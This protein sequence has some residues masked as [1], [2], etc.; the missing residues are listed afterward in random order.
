MKFFNFVLVLAVVKSFIL[1]S[2]ISE[3]QNIKELK[4]LYLLSFFGNQKEMDALFKTKI[5][6]PKTI[7]EVGSYLGAST[8]YLANQLAD[9]GALY[10]VDWWRGLNYAQEK[11]VPGDHL[12]GWGHKL[13]KETNMYEQFL[14]NMVHLGVDSK[15]FP[16]RSKTLDAVA[17]LHE[18]GVHQ[19]DL[20]YIDADHSYSVVLEELKA[21]FH[22][23]EGKKGIIC[24]DDWLWSAP[25]LGADYILGVQKA[26]KKFCLDRGLKYFSVNNFWW[27]EE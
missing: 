7:I 3:Y 26:V 19:A 5:G 8:H 27:I 2:E 25:N 12:T 16:I 15:V 9:G 24:G 17:K 14:S 21:Y 20:I 22:F 1:C 11:P 18:K 6:Q 10:A 4:P 13:P 23:V